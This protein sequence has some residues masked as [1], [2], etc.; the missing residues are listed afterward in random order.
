M[1]KLYCFQKDDEIF[2]CPQVIYYQKKSV[3]EKLHIHYEIIRIVYFSNLELRY[4]INF[5]NVSFFRFSEGNVP[6]QILSH[7]YIAKLLSE[8]LY[9]IR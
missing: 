2:P 3:N 5:K 4:S 8:A 1:V 9:T 7:L 6:E